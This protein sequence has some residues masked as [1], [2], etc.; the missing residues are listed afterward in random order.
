MTKRVERTRIIG[1]NAVAF[2]VWEPTSGP[3]GEHSTKTTFDEVW[4]GRVGTRR[5]TK[6]LDAMK[7]GSVERINAVQAF[8]NAQYEEAY[9]DIIAAHPEAAGGYR[10]MGEITITVE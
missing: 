10:S 1:T 7:P 9:A 3:M 5:L 8:Q 4:H 6:E 2:S